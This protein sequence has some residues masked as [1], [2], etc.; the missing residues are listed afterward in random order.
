LNIL[1]APQEKGKV[2]LEENL[3]H[4]GVHK[5]SNFSQPCLPLWFD[6]HIS[7]FNFSTFAYGKYG[8]NDSH[9]FAIFFFGQNYPLNSKTFVKTIMHIVLS[10]FVLSQLFV[11]HREG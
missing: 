10:C 5:K 9:Y 2:S 3:Q 7:L 11:G 6:M 1:F 8:S 4:L